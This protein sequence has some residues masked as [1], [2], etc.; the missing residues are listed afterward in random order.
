MFY[1][2]LQY[3]CTLLRAFANSARHFLGHVACNFYFNMFVALSSHVFLHVSAFSQGFFQ[4]LLELDDFLMPFSC[5]I[6]FHLSC[7]VLAL[8]AL[9]LQLKLCKF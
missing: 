1:F 5:A 4:T 8:V 9:S 6:V 3:F 2:L 7:I